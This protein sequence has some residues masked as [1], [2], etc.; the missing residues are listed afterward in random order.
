MSRI[1]YVNGRYL[2][3]AHAKVSIED[4]GYQ[5][6]DGVYEVCEVRGGRLVD[7]RRHMARLDRSL[8]ELRIARPM[9]PAAL[10]DRVAGNGAAQPRARRHR[11]F[12]DHPRRGA[13]GFS[14]SAGGHDGLRGGDRAQ[15]RSRAARTIGGRRH[16]RRHRARHPLAA[17]R[18][19]IGGPA[20]ECAGQAGRARAGRARGL[21]GRR[22]K[23]AS[24]KAPRRM[25][26]S[27]AATASSSRI[28][29]AAISCPGS[30]AR[31]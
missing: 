5:F 30:R 18:H 27:S 12:A 14:V 9:S 28:R 29:S 6:A 11:L 15:Q 22:R 3:R 19:Q 2:P 13:A 4:R 31:S 21:A 20:A 10:V 17:R 26:G 7:E 16:R 25:P 23:A 24:P 8:N 1:A